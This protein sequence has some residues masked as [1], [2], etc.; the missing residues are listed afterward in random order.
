MHL[1][2]AAGWLLL[3]NPEEA[4]ADFQRIGSDSR[5]HPDTLE[6]EWSIQ[7]ARGKWEECATT[8]AIL[9]EVA[10]DRVS[11]WINRAYATRRMNPDGIHKAW[12]LLLPAVSRFPN[13]PIVP[14]NLACYAC[15][16]ERTE[17]ALQ[18][19]ERALEKVADKRGK[20]DLLEL[21]TRDEDLE[22]LQEKIRNQLKSLH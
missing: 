6:T 8:A 4:W 2:A 22:P 15:Q 20:Q 21:A 3:G 10:G 17:E 5:R 14:Y 11:G 1:E 9:I 7:A 19:L 13:E 12:D 16:L 18:W